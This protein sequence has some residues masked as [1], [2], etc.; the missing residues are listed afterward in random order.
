MQRC[1][2]PAWPEAGAPAQGYVVLNRP[3][4]FQQWAH[5]ALPGLEEDYV[6]MAEPDHIFLKPLP[7]WYEPGKHRYCSVGRHL[8]PPLFWVAAV[9]IECRLLVL[10]RLVGPLLGVGIEPWHITPHTHLPIFRAQGRLLL[11]H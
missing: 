7:L 2:M 8:H 4:A 11:L 6:L 1:I 10:L 3:Y 5:Q 9:S